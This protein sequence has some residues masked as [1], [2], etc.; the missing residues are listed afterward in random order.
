MVVRVIMLRIQFAC[1][2]RNAYF[3]WYLYLVF[4]S[5][6]CIGRDEAARLLLSRG[7]SVD[8][9]YLGLTPLHFAAGYGMIGVMK[10]LLEHHADVRHQISVHT[11]L[12]KRR[13]K[14]SKDNG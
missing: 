5:A 10:V 12:F 6:P 13:R 11:A 9:A 3:S 7:A 4:F 14:I 2:A 8:V 1:C